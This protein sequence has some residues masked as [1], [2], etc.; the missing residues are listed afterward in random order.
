MAWHLAGAKHARYGTETQ[1]AASMWGGGSMRVAWQGIQTM[2]RGL[3]GVVCAPFPDN[4]I[5]VYGGRGE[6]RG[7]MMGQGASNHKK[8]RINSQPTG[9][10][11][12]P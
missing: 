4:V 1:G 12:S 9:L 5:R 11:A 10:Q 3:Q 6:K 2:L 7:A 8:G